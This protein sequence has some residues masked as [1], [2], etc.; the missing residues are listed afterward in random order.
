VGF[1]ARRHA[2]HRAEPTLKVLI[3]R[4]NYLLQQTF[5]PRRVGTRTSIRLPSM[6]QAFA[7]FS[8][9]H[10]DLVLAGS[11]FKR[12]AVDRPIPWPPKGMPEVSGMTHRTFRPS[13]EPLS[14]ADLAL[15]QRVFL[16]VCIDREAGTHPE[17]ENRIAAITIELYRHGVRN[18]DHL[19]EMVSA[20]RG[21]MLRLE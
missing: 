7:I 1:D 9:G 10:M 20:A 21:A 12:L 16:A 5:L 14:P 17:E 18:E 15:C 2:K 4:R 11:F 19:R 8:I 13:D 6:L 3:G